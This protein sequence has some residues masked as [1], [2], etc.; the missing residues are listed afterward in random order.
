MAPRKTAL[1]LPYHLTVAEG[2]ESL[3]F[4][5]VLMGQPE[6]VHLAQPGSF[7]IESRL[8]DTVYPVGQNASPVRPS[9]YPSQ[10]IDVATDCTT[11][12]RTKI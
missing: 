8:F 7:T 5:G 4:H 2:H 6:A 10:G 11:P 3:V 1:R 12:N 9:H